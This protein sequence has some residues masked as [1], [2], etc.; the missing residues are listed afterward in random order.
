[1]IKT[2]LDEAGLCRRV[3]LEARP[4]GGKLSLPYITKDLEQ[5]DGA[6]QRLVLIHPH[7]A[8]IIKE[9]DLVIAQEG[10]YQKQE[11]LE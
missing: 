11:E 9:K 3:T 8:E 2:F 10:T 7:E 5:F 1:M 6:T 4:R